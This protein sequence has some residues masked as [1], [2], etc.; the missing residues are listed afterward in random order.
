MK[1]EDVCYRR[2]LELRS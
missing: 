2:S 1:V